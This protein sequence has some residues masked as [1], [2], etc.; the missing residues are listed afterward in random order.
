MARNRWM[1]EH[2]S[3]PYVKRAQAAGYR[4][5]ALFKLQEID[6]QDRLIRPHSVVADLGCAPG[7][8]SQYVASRLGKGG[9]IV[10]VDILPMEPL[11][12]VVFIHGDF[13]DPQCFSEVQRALGDH[14]DLVISDMAPNISGIE[15][16]D[17]AHAMELAEMALDFASSCLVADGRC[18]I[19]VFQGAGFAE[20]LAEMRRRFNRVVTRK[21]PAS[22]PRSPEVYLLGT[23]LRPVVSGSE[24]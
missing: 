18:L 17:Q 7:G 11:A 9:R 3:D 15:A 23:G 22:R 13:T 4:S 8:F 16:A 10:A 12:G 20:L 21:P 6:A 2:F 5:R 24:S 19:K 1:A 14:V